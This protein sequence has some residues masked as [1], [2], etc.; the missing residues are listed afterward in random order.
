M[1]CIFLKVYL[2]VNKCCR[3]L[4]FLFVVIFVLVFCCF[5]FFVVLVWLWFSFESVMWIS[6]FCLFLLRKLG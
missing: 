2:F 4:L 5:V 6:M 3:L 1:E